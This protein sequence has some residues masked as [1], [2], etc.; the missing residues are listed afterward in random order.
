MICRRGGATVANN[1][2]FCGDCGTP[3]PWQ[4]SACGS[5]NPADKRFCGDCGASRGATHNAIQPVAA[6]SP[7]RRL[8]SVMFIDLVGSTAIGERL[9]AEDV[10]EVVAA[11]HGVVRGLVTWFDGFIARYMGDGVL[12]YF[13]YPQAHEADAERAIRVGL[14]IVEA[15]ASLDTRAGPAGTLSVRIGVD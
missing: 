6:P 11:F 8:L 4:C 12:V 15:V 9:D 5:D 10:R 13:G 3:L 1:R 2:K 14:A 7:E